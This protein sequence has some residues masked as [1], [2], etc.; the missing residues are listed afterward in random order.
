M[1]EKPWRRQPAYLSRQANFLNEKDVAME[2]FINSSFGI[3]LTYMFS[4]HFTDRSFQSFVLLSYGWS[5]SRVRHTIANYIW[6]SGGVK[7]K[8]FSQFYSFLSGSFLK[9]LPALWKTVLL[10]I[11]KMLPPD[12][13]L[14]LMIDDTT[15]KKSGRKI[16][17]AGTYRNGAGTARQEY[18][19]LWGLN[20]VY[21]LLQFVWKTNGKCYK[22]GL[23]VGLRIYLK[24]EKAKQLSRAFHSRSYLARQ[25]LDFIAQVLAHRNFLVKADGGYSTKEFLRNL[26]S[27]VE[28]DGRFPINSRLHDL[29]IQPK[30]RK[31]GRP[32]KKGKDL[33]T[34][35]EW[36]QQ[37]QGWEPHPDEADVFIKTFRGVWHSVLPNVLITVVVVWRKNYV[38]TDSQSGK[39]ELEA[40]FST[41]LCFSPRQILQHYSQRW[42]VEIDIRDG[43]AYYGLGK[44]HCRRFDRIFGANSFRLL[45]ATCRTLWF[46]RQFE[47]RT[48][49]LKKYRPWYRQ[50]TNPSQ[51]DVCTAAQEAFISEGISPIPRFIVGMA[52]IKQTQEQPI[53]QVA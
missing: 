38:S 13:V 44:D 8:H 21:V 11:D 25:M 53:A 34:P 45:M 37:E 42:A 39:K 33:G 16:E 26:P 29:P 19:S 7:Y 28:V 14:S 27:N 41:D 18:R 22:L 36:V 47:N 30:K 40:F 32:C 15:R 48:L 3:F 6:L 52:T 24:E 10:L 12:L 51:L 9:M 46:I 17:G 4:Q 23:P 20:F 50:K 43:Y 35:K 49:A 5:F 31:V 2:I 1:K